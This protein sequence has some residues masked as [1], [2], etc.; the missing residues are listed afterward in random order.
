MVGL[1]MRGHRAGENLVEEDRSLVFPS[2]VE[3]L[4]EITELR[5]RCVDRRNAVRS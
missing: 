2:V 1:D 3:H 4:E 5:D